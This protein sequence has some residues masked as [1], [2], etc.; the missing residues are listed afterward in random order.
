MNE[1]KSIEIRV[2]VLENGSYPIKAH[3]TDAGFDLF[4]TEDLLINKGD[5][6]KHPLGFK[7]ELPENTYGHIKCKSG[8]GSKGLLLLAEIIDQDYRG[9]PTLVA[10]NISNEPIFIKKG[11][12]C[13]QM[14][15]HPFGPK[16]EITPVLFVCEDTKRGAGGF[17]SSGA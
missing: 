10:T 7:M 8:L 12:K 17:G 13:C 14:I 15:I 5:I 6:I 9:Q 4:A 3:P 1:S 11:Q 2:Q 16:Y